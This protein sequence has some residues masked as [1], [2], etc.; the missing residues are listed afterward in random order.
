MDEDA[1]GSPTRLEAATTVFALG[2]LYWLGLSGVLDGVASAVR[3]AA[4][5]APEV[6]HGAR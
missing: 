6:P 5:R 2:E 4:S 3:S 1:L